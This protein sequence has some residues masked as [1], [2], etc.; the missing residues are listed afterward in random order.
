VTTPAS[1]DRELLW[2]AAPAL[3]G[4][5]WQTPLARLLDCD[6]RL[7]RRWAAGSREVPLWVLQRLAEE[8]DTRR[9]AVSAVCGALE[10]RLAKEAACRD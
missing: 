6:D 8:L 4:D 9:V 1:G 2:L 3:L 5:S 7:V 10:S